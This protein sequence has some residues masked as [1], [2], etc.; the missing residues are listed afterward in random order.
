[1]QDLN[2]LRRLPLALAVSAALALAAC[3]GSDNNPPRLPKP[4]GT[5]T[6]SK[7]ARLAT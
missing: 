4:P 5:N 2:L 7:W 3:G 6:P 1:M